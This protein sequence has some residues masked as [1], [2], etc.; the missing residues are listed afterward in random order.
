MLA[1]PEL[2]AEAAQRGRL[3]RVL[4]GWLREIPLYRQ[5]RGQPPAAGFTPETE[6]LRG[7]PFITKED[8]RRDFPRNF[9][10]GTTDLESLIER[11][12]IELEHTSGTSEARTPLLLPRGWWTEQEQRALR[13]NPLVAKILDHDAE[14]RRVTISSPVCSGDICYTGVPS[15]EDRVVGQALFVNLSR[16]P[17]LWSEA[18]KDRMAAEALEWQPRFLDVDPVYGALF[19][20]HCERRGIRL[21]T[22]E[23]ILCSYEFVSVVHRRILQRA[24][25]AP[26]FNLYGSTETG[27]L[28]MENPSGEMQPGYETACLD[29]FGAGEEGIGELIVSTLTNPFMPLINYRI[30]DLVERRERAWGARYL[31][32][33]RVADAFASPAGRRVTT[34][35]IDQCFADLEGV[36]H[37]QLIERKNA[38]WL[39]RFVPAGAGP[40][41]A[42]IDTLRRR[43]SDLL[44]LSD[45]LMI[46]P[47]E[48]LAPERSGKFRLG[49][50]AEHG[51]KAEAEV[52][53][54]ETART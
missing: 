28:L 49:Y 39:L 50:P 42:V 4:P 7:L 44:E 20:L 41:G 32:H 22:L 34:W 36:A 40:G 2:I 27:H 37:Y 19:A 33:G 43:L 11:E 1:T 16:Y 47:V 54:A 3:A 26:V 13:L 25:R 35:Q 29:L 5:I 18:D 14:A 38:P 6:G 51:E 10:G 8:I 30:G 31:V 15:R 45:G 48:M 46:Q 12:V 53:S 52:A 23:F 17:F 21:P 9:L 24:F